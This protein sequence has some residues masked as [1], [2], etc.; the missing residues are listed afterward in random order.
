MKNIVINSLNGNLRHPECIYR[1][2]RMT[3]IIKYPGIDCPKEVETDNK[4]AINKLYLSYKI[5]KIINSKILVH[6]KS[7]KMHT[8]QNRIQNRNQ[9]K[10][11]DNKSQQI[12]RRIKVKIKIKI[13]VEIR[14]RI[15]Q[16]HLH[17]IKIIKNQIKSTTHQRKHLSI[18]QS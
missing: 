6:S 11:R 13:R 7:H 5:I 18:P 16:S 17:H 14:I 9:N 10:S 15:K 1:T 4:I 12:V 2:C 3:P 8:N